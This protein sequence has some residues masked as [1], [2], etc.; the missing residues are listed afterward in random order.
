M[1]FSDSDWIVEHQTP[2]F[3]FMTIILLL[4]LHAFF[5]SSSVKVVLVCHSLAVFISFLHISTASGP[6]DAAP[7]R[8]L[9]SQ[10]SDMGSIPIIFPAFFSFSS[11]IPVFT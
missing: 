7:A 1:F 8:H 2:L 4:L 3:I 9:V 5:N 11:V 10:T 6:W